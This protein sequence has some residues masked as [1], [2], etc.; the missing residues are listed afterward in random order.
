MALAGSRHPRRRTIF[1]PLLLLASAATVLFFGFFLID[2]TTQ[3][4]KYGPLTTLLNFDPDTLENALG[5]LSQVLAA[6]LGIVITVVSIVVQLAATRYTPRIAE[7]FFRDRTNLAVLGFFVVAAIQSVWVALTIGPD[8][9]PR[10]SI[11]VSLLLTTT[12]VLLMVPYFAY[13]FEFLDPER[14]VARIQDQAV[15]SATG[16]APGGEQVGA[17]QTRVLQSIEQLADIA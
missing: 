4:H 12:S 11:T 15:A 10:L 13:V 14:V 9:V 1:Y 2:W 7:M 8:F 16:D 5:N 6:V 3:V 17:R